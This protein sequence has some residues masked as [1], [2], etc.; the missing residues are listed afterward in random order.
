LAVPSFLEHEVSWKACRKI[1]LHVQIAATISTQ[2]F[3]STLRLKKKR[4]E[5]RIGKSVV[6]G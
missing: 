3:Q 5:S 1:N 2:K 4:R 6:T